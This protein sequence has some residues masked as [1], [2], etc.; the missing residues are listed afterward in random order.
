MINLNKQS[1]E[2]LVSSCY[3]YR[4]LS[5]EQLFELLEIYDCLIIISRHPNY[6]AL[7]SKE[8][9]DKRLLMQYIQN[10]RKVI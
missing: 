1:F 10:E 3:N 6:Y 7:E 4:D 5:N 8:T 2:L 9:E